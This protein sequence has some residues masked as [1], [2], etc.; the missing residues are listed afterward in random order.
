M[1]SFIGFRGPRLSLLLAS[2]LAIGYAGT[3]RIRFTDVVDRP[4]K[5]YQWVCGEI[6]ADLVGMK[7]PPRG[8]TQRWIDVPGRFTGTFR[9][10][11]YPNRRRILPTPP[12]PP[13]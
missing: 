12:S 11:W 9:A 10:E 3:V 8:S 2:T 1:S 13:E 5:P 4:G 6:S 7:D